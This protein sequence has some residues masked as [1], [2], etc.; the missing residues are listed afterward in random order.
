[1]LWLIRH[2]FLE[3]LVALSVFATVSALVLPKGAFDLNPDNSMPVDAI[4]PH[5]AKTSD[6]GVLQV[7]LTSKELQPTGERQLNFVL[8]NSGNS[9]AYY[10]G[11]TPNSFSPRLTNGHVS[12]IYRKQMKLGTTWQDKQLG[13]CGNGA[14]RMRLLPGHAARF[15]AWQDA[16]E[17]AIQIGVS[18]SASKIGAYREEDVA[19]SAVIAWE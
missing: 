13:W 16:T 11:Y 18:C 1:M 2:R 7:I 3:C 14:T 19:W 4:L 10:V 9:P 5:Y 12:P 15:T 17:P 8:L 6:N